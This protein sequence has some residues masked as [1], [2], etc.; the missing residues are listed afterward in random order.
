MTT[1]KN[2]SLSDVLFLTYDIDGDL[3]IALEAFLRKL[4]SQENL[5]KF[6]QNPDT[7]EK[8]LSEVVWDDLHS[9]SYKHEWYVDY[10][11]GPDEPYTH[12]FKHID[13]IRESTQLF[14][15]KDGKEVEAK[16]ICGGW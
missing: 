1:T 9:F 2:V 4:F 14:Y 6:V 10:E 12:I 13:N 11:G 7:M 16:D 3:L 15:L 8:L 5:D